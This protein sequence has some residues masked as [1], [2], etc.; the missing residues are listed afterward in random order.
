MTTTPIDVFLSTPTSVGSGFQPGLDNLRL[1]LNSHGLHPRTVGVT[2]SGT[3]PPMDEVIH[4]MAQCRGVVILGYPQIVPTTGTLRDEP[5]A[6]PLP[7]AT[8]W[9]HIEA[10]LAYAKGKPLLVI[11][12]LGVSRGVFDHGAISAH[13]YEEDLEKRDWFLNEPVTLAITAWIEEV[14]QAPPSHTH[15]ADRTNA[16]P[17]TPAR[18]RDTTFETCRGC[19]G[20]GEIFDI[21]LGTVKHEACKGLGEF[22]IDDSKRVRPCRTCGGEGRTWDILQGGVDCPRCQG[23][24]FNIV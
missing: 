23:K 18:T 3:K 15:A 17:I 10:A 22:P 8:E 19:N 24:G 21:L 14:K 11:H 5:L 12:H 9:N 16:P 1:F 20:T 2:E 13:I 4:L 7:L 6:Q